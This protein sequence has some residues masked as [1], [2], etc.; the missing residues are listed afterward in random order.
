MKKYLITSLVFIILLAFLFSCAGVVY[1]PD[2]PPGPK[3][4]VKPPRPGP[5]AF[6]IDGHWN[7]SGGQWVWV[8]G[9]WVKNP[10]SNWVAGHWQKT[11]HGWKWNKGHWK[12]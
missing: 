7:W 12:R 9:Y 2:Q 11:P 6:W 5:K 4:E 1:V 10:K 8:S 3:N